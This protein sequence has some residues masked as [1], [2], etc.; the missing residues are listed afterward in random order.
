MPCVSAVEGDHRGGAWGG[1]EGALQETGGHA[2]CAPMGGVRLPQG[3]DGHPQFGQ[4]SAGLGAAA[5][6]L[7]PR[8]TPSG[9]L[10]R[11]GSKKG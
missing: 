8:A 1:S 10:R 5:G 11:K 7:A 3:R 9:S 4:T 6:A 2:R